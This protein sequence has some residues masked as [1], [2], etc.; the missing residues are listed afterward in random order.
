MTA[1]GVPGPGAR[2]GLEGLVGDPADSM[3]TSSDLLW[4]PVLVV[5]VV[6]VRLMVDSDRWRSVA[7]AG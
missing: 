4:A 6:M 1:C 5:S 7:M 3:A 2:V